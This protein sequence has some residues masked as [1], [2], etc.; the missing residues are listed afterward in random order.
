MILQFS[1]VTFGAVMLTVPLMSSPL[2]TAPGVL[3]VMLPEDFSVTPSF[4]PVF[5]ASG[6][7]GKS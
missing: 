1:T 3:T 7:P 6:N 2:I 4:T 5:D